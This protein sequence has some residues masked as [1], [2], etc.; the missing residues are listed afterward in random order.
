MGT[1]A[2]LL[3]LILAA[4]GQ[5]RSPYP[6]A[7]TPA[8]GPQQPPPAAALPPATAPP[9]AQAAAK[10][11][12]AKAAQIPEPWPQTM[13]AGL[14]AFPAG[15]VPDNPPPAAVVSRAWQLLSSLWASGRPGAIKTEQTAGR[16]ITYQATYH[17]GNKRGV[18]AFRLRDAG[19]SSAPSSTSSPINLT[20]AP[21]SRA[22]QLGPAPSSVPLPTSL[23]QGSGM[24]ALAAQAPAVKAVQAKLGVP[25]DGKFGPATRAAVVAFQQRNGLT[26]DGIVGPQTSAKL[27]VMA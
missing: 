10:A 8:P 1:I 19:A 3:F 9:A 18:T 23:R 4:R 27:G 21:S 20:N 13:P 26:P 5:E 14:P 24:G 11:A 15:W 2:F 17:P 16:W 6:T 25:A 12:Q 7:P 22:P